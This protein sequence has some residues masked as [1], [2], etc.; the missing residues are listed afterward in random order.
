MIELDW[1]S[2]FDSFFSLVKVKILCKDPTR[3]P[4]GRLYVFKARVY[5]ILFNPKGYVQAD[6]STDGDSRD[7]EELEEDDLLDDDD[8]KDN[9]KGNDD[10]PKKDKDHEPWERELPEPSDKP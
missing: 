2:V 5:K 8:P 10:D 1:H 3:I 7:V 9:P 4:K 6:T